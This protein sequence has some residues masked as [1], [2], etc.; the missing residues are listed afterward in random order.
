MTS[1]ALAELPVRE[2]VRLF[3]RACNAS[4]LGDY[5][6]L[7]APDVRSRTGDLTATG[8]DAVVRFM[9]AVRTTFPDLSVTFSHVLVS[10]DEVA[11]ELVERGTH[12]GPLVLPGRTLPPTG[13]RVEW[14]AA[15]FF[16][17]DENGLI[18]SLRD[19][20]DTAALLRQLEG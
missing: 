6:A 11:A 16:R 5:A 1:T 19:Y 12:R 2:R 9:T 4:G 7:L 8:R 14:H 15:T 18:R 3:E 17:Y 10:G 13:R 20:L